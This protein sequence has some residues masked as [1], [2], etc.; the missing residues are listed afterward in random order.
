MVGKSNILG[1][2]TDRS[3]DCDIVLSS[4]I[5]MPTTAELKAG[6][7]NFGRFRGNKTAYCE[8][9]YLILLVIVTEKA[10]SSSLRKPLY[11]KTFAFGQVITE[12]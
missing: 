9:K 2:Q 6:K 11:K 7:S 3:V 5:T 4:D 12:V 10:T 1:F 8:K